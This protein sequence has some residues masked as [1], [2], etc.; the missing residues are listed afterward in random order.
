M[1]SVCRWAPA[2]VGGFALVAGLALAGVHSLRAEE[3]GVGVQT[4]RTVRITYKAVM[5]VP[6]G[7]EDARLWLPLPPTSDHQTV[8]GL[9]V[10]ANVRHS[11]YTEPVYGNTVVCAEY[12]GDSG[13]PIVITLT[14]TIRREGYRML[15]SRAADPRPAAPP[16]RA[17]DDDVLLPELAAFLRPTSMIPLTGKVEAEAMKVV[18]PGMSDEQKARAMYDY[19]ART[20][21]YDKTVPG[22]GRG[23]AIRACDIRKGN[24]TD[25]HSLFIGMARATKLPARFLMGFPL[26]ADKK[27]GK[28]SGYHCWAEFYMEG[29]GWVP[30]DISEAAQH[31]ERHE[32]L[33]GGLD[34]DRV[35]FTTGRDIQLCP[36]AQPGP[37][38]YLI[39]PVGMIDGELVNGVA[40][41]FAFEDV[42]P[43]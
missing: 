38:N 33:Y 40:W 18:R 25:F 15:A 5:P 42:E 21:S 34:A 43:E 27:S 28:V 11:R 2:W 19:L 16:S 24:C 13:E 32:E 8:S 30:V 20:L 22:Y 31:P 35:H 37:Q 26:P 7:A 4:A 12:E 3:G 6:P 41:E 1:V 10:E 23:D 17:L 39:Y 36:G 14:A 9:R 29:T